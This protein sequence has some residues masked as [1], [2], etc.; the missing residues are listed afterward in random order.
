MAVIREL[1]YATVVKIA[2]GEVIDRPA[3][4]VRELIDNS[5]DAGAHEISVH[6]SDGGKGLLEVI[7]DGCG[8]EPDDLS[9]C[10]KNHST[11]KIRSFD[12][13]HS[14]STL[15]FRGEA[16]ASIASVSK[17]SIYSRTPDALSGHVIRV[18]HGQ[19]E[20]V[21]ETGMG[22]GTR[23]VVEGLFDALPAR[24]K[25]LSTASVELKF[26]EREIIKKALAHP[27]TGFSLFNEGKK[28][29][30]SPRRNTMLERI[31]DFYPDAVSSLVPV[32]FYRDNVSIGGFVSRPAFIRPNR[33]VE[34]LFA[35][36][37]WAEWK[38]FYF[39]L[40][41]AYG[42]LIPKGHFPAAFLMIDL[43]PEMLDVNV[44]PM[45]REVRFWNDSKL[46]TMVREAVQ[47][48]IRADIGFEESHENPMHFTPYEKVVGEALRDYA[49]TNLNG[50]QP[51]RVSA[52]GPAPFP[53]PQRNMEMR[54]DTLPLP[55]SPSP[56]GLW[57][58]SPEAEKEESLADYRFAGSLFHTYLIFEHGED[59]VFFDQ[60]AAHERMNYEKLRAQYESRLL[61]PQELLVPVKVDVPKEL[62]SEFENKLE[63][64]HSMGFEV[65]P[66]GGESFLVRSVPVFLDYGAAEDAVIGFIQALEEDASAQPADFIDR[67]LKQ[68]ACKSSIRAGDAVSAIEA[69]ALIREWEKTPNRHSCPHGRPV[70]FKLPKKELEKQFKRLGF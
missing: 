57:D 56:S 42:N 14:L 51:R 37:R 55:E 36:G 39:A 50:E 21:V 58:S 41:Q 52:P 47:T 67:A 59:A 34:H 61:S 23:I 35:N 54:G 22:K 30:Q 12:D 44:H 48:A 31:A 26:L 60:H 16:L 32:E 49:E 19:T 18:A 25:F 15:G 63:L 20:G 69:K 11:S 17:L 66:F 5:I 45:K 28:K 7:D 2:A 6:I 24:K 9:L 43:P 8:M 29:W 40:N 3:S 38:H 53:A 27:E 10:V 4:V 46:E 65:E 64:L 68:I 62:V 13:I 70:A 1:D 33:M